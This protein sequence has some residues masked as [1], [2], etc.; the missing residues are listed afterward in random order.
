MSLDRIESFLEMMQA[1][2]G[3]SINTVCSYR[4]DLIGFL[5]YLNQV[6]QELLTVNSFHIRTYL[7][8][9]KSQ[10]ASPRT[11]SRHL[12]AIREF[13]RFSYSEGWIKENPCDYVETPKISKTLP[14]YLTETEVFNL[15]QSAQKENLRLYLCK[16][17]GL[18]F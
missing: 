3:S 15:I 8:Y 2:R 14:K 11:Q 13:Y 6:N 12:S 16:F 1:E 5:E 17:Q 18:P 7:N 10:K 9:L 4:R